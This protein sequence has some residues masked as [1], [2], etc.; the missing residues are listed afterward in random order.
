MSEENSVISVNENLPIEQKDPLLSMI[1]KVCTD[2]DFDLSKM[3]KLIDMRNAELARQAQVDYAVAV[4]QMQSELP[5]VVCDI[6]GHNSKY[7][8]FDNIKKTVNPILSK[9]GFKDLY[10]IN[11]N[12]KSVTI[13]VKLMHKSGHF[14]ETSIT[15]P[16]ETSGNKNAVQ[17][18]GSTISYGR[19]YGLLS[20]LGVATGDDNDGEQFIASCTAKRIKDIL[21][22]D[23]LNEKEFL[24]KMNVDCVENILS[25]DFEKANLEL[26]RKLKEQKALFKNQ[27]TE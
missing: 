27:T 18:I 15:L 23:N 25:K 12:E 24:N 8:S 22:K 11:Q 16:H 3:E 21:Q 4:S 13:N 10:Y 19:R 2:K 7:A 20:I 6:D 1:D 9:Y 26:G 17:A 5:T 14:E